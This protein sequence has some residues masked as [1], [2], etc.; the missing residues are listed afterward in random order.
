M[1]PWLDGANIEQFSKPQ[2]VIEI[3]EIQNPEQE[4]QLPVF[5]TT[6]ILRLKISICFGN[7]LSRTLHNSN[8]SCIFALPE[9]AK[10]LN[11]AQMC[12]SFFIYIHGNKN[13]LFES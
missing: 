12:G 3:I 4:A 2:K 6:K 1:Y 7:L 9:P 8:D 11:D 10:P 13:S 5:L